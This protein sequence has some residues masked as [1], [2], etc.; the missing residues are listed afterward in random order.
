MK[1]VSNYLKKQANEDVIAWTKKL[2]EELKQILPKSFIQARFV[3]RL[4]KS[5]QIDMT[6]GKDKSEYA[7]GIEHND[8]LRQTIF[9][10]SEPSDSWSESGLPEKMKAENQGGI[11]FVEPEAGSQYAR[12]RVKLGWRNKT[13]TPDVIFKYIVDYVK[14]VKQIIKENNDKLPKEIQNKY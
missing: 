9:I 14:K 4:G 10:W 13:A 3:T 1:K 6:L 5:I 8:P 2:D 11:L 7:H 12:G